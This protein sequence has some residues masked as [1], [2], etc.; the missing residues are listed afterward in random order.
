MNVYPEYIHKDRP[1]NPGEEAPYTGELELE[2][3]AGK[4]IGAVLM[5][6][7]KPGEKH[8]AAILLHGFP[9]HNNLSDIGQALRRMGF[10][11]ICPYAPGAWGSGGYYTFD[12]LIKAAEAL[13]AYA[14]GEGGEIYHIC[15]DNIF[16]IGHS[17]GGYTCVNAMRRLPGIKA[18]VCLM[19]FDYP[20][21]FEKG[22]VDIIK[23]LFTLGSILR[24][25]TETSLF[26]NALAHYENTAFSKAS[27]DLKDRN[28]L[29]IGGVRDDVAPV[30]TMIEPL[31]ESIKALGGKA[32]Y[33]L[34]ETDHS[35]NDSRFKVCETIADF[36]CPLVD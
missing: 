27:E 28:L 11:A 20:W 7:H 21:F 23:N 5:P 29:F 19:P 17:M 30:K 32:Q 34:L 36:I 25:E 2:T 15:P 26:E 13:A 4:V 16:I 18:G 33:V 31:Y 24:Q 14:A 3:E 12:G 1:L 22:E 6:A 8:P 9:G 35:F 10:V